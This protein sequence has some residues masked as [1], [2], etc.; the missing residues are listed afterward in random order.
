MSS[1]KQYLLL[2]A[3]LLLV[4]AGCSTTPNNDGEA[5]ELP[6]SVNAELSGDAADD[7]PWANVAPAE[8][9]TWSESGT[10]EKAVEE[11]PTDKSA[12]GEQTA[13]KSAADQSPKTNDGDVTAVQTRAKTAST[14]VTLITR[15]PEQVKQAQK[16][17]Q[18]YN[19]ALL[20]MKKGNLDGALAQF[21]QLAGKYPALGGPVVNQAIILRKKGQLD[22]A[23]KLLQDALL[24]HGNNPYLLN[25]L[26]VASREQGQFKKAQASYES[27]IRVDPN[28]AKAH[29]N[30]GVLADLYLHDP[31][32]ALQEFQQYQTLVPEPDKQ[33]DGWIKELERRIAKQKS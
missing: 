1:T 20:E 26:G 18:E 31:N 3:A 2:T 17:T 21:K 23:H 8:D 16:A 9:A 11:K 15:D 24:T 6:D 27:A 19:Q 22:T 10:T 13:V 14:P 12:S 33:V 5:L 7:A 4:L 29:Y 32:L 25:E 30:L 28:Y